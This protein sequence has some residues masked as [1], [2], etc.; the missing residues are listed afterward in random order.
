MDS[1]EGQLGGPCLPCLHSVLHRFF[2]L[3]R[4]DSQERGYG[5]IKIE[6][7]DS[8]NR[9]RYQRTE[10]KEKTKQ[11]NPYKERKK[12]RSTPKCVDYL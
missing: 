4:R 2:F 1:R 10:E 11:K 9:K 7:E 8:K 5:I 6:V 3:T 12:A